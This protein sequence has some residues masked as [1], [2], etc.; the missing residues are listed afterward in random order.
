MGKGQRKGRKKEE[1]KSMARRQRKS[2]RIST[3]L[4]FATI[5]LG[6]N[7]IIALLQWNGVTMP[8]WISACAYVFLA[9]SMVAAFWNWEVSSRWTTRRRSRWAIVIAVALLSVSVWG[10]RTQ[11]RRE[12][13]ARLGSRFP[14]G[15]ERFVVLKDGGALA[16]YQPLKSLASYNFDITWGSATIF[17]QTDAYLIVKLRDVTIVRTEPTPSGPKQAGT[18]KINGEAIWQIDRTSKVVSINNGMAFWGYVL[19]GYV[20]SDSGDEV[21]VAVGLQKITQTTPASN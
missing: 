1:N 2:R 21:E 8:W 16:G 7:F 10:I 19:G 20:T 11:Y 3:S 4:F 15:F 5:A 17:N 9:S 14:G 18:I 6:C 13:I 12:V